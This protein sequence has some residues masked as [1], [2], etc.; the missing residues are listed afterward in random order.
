MLGTSLLHIFIYFALVGWCSAQIEFSGA[1]RP[2]TSFVDEDIAGG[3]LISRQRLFSS[4]LPIINTTAYQNRLEVNERPLEAVLR[5]RCKSCLTLMSRDFLDFFVEYLPSAV[6]EL[7]AQQREAAK[8]LALTLRKTA[9]EIETSIHSYDMN[10]MDKRLS[11]TMGILIYNGDFNRKVSSKMKE[12]FFEA[13]FWSMYRYFR[14][15]IVMTK[16]T[17]DMQ[18]VQKLKLPVSRIYNFNIILQSD[19]GDQSQHAANS[20]RDVMQGML[21][22]HALE[23]T[24]ITWDEDPSWA[25]FQY[26]MILNADQLLHGRRFADLY[27]LLDTPGTDGQVVLVP[28]RMPTLPIAKNFPVELRE[29]QWFAW[30][31]QPV[32]AAPKQ[33]EINTE[34]RDGI[35][36]DWSL[37]GDARGI[38]SLEEAHEEAE[39]KEPPNH[40]PPRSLQQQGEGEFRP[41]DVEEIKVEQLQPI[42]VNKAMWLPQA[43]ISTE[44][45]SEV[46]GS[47][48]EAG[49]FVFPKCSRQTG[50]N[51]RVSDFIHSGHGRALFEDNFEPIEPSLERLKSRFAAR[52]T[53]AAGGHQ[54]AGEGSGNGGGKRAKG[55]GSAASW[56]S[57]ADWGARNFTSWL[58]VGENGFAFPPVTTNLAYCTYSKTAKT[59]PLPVMRKRSE[60]KNTK[61]VRSASTGVCSPACTHGKAV[62]VPA[63]NKRGRLSAT[64]TEW[65]RDTEA[66]QH[67]AHKWERGGHK[68][69]R[70]SRQ[71]ARDDELRNSGYEV[72]GETPQ[73]RFNVAMTPLLNAKD[74]L[75]LQSV[76]G[77]ASC[78]LDDDETTSSSSSAATTDPDTDN[79]PDDAPHVKTAKINSG[80]QQQ[81]SPTTD[82]SSLRW[83]R[84]RPDV[85]SV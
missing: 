9:R 39:E 16:S 49:R 10:T 21:T 4:L 13:S 58:K 73:M 57:C 38:R 32:V 44:K 6:N 67:N 75:L 68:A 50:K 81:Q 51:M 76:F 5:L 37:S 35:F 43:S 82:E 63:L 69:H 61:N 56:M 52:T 12:H 64:T 24:L 83:R 3:A 36:R 71:R 48:C 11:S 77:T 20:A 53:Q 65:N 72:C 40:P 14:H 1:Y 27:N 23:Q 2:H 62:R 22:K 18:T 54:Q 66:P 45:L 41:E 42:N 80:E 78:A 25:N 34:M 85:D 7:A 29:K 46:E 84:Q 8:H 79:S 33:P 47:C 55:G 19:R 74:K 17:E 28:H 59:C 31:E 26:A 60:F 30:P 70:N 15:I